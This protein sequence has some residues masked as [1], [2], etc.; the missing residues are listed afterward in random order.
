MTTPEM[1]VMF[2]QY[3][4]QM[5]MQNVRAILPEQIDLVLN[6]SQMDV[7]NQII[8]ENIGITNDRIISDNSKIGQVNALRS[9]YH[10]CH[11]DM[12][13]SSSQLEETRAF[14]FSAADRNT[15]RMT[16]DFKKISDNPLIPDYMFLVDF[17][18]NYKKVRNQQGYN[19][20]TGIRIKGTYSVLTPESC[21]NGG[22]TY[23]QAN[24]NINIQIKLEAY[25]PITDNFA[26][27]DF[28]PDT[29]VSNNP[30]LKCTTEGFTE[31]YLG[32]EGNKDDGSNY[33][34]RHYTLTKTF[35]DG[36]DNYNKGIIYNPLVIHSNNKISDYVAPIFEE[37]GLETNYFPVRI[38]DDAYLADTLNDFILKNRLRSPIIVT[39]NNNKKENIFD[40]YIDKF[41]KIGSGTT[42]KY[43][44][45]GD[46]LPY[47]LR[48]SY[49]GKPINIYYGEDLGKPNQDCSL[50]E[51]MHVDIVK[52]AVDLWRAAVTGSVL[53][54]QQQEQNA[55][56]ENMRNNYRNEGNAQ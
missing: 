33:G 43:V 17:S 36:D 5:G 50:P 19:G 53:A 15:G 34:G 31:Y 29:S 2:R 30:R 37:D 49:I 16:T 44:L 18:L 13:P 9:L 51:Y 1:H 12:S 4:Q 52:H 54:A 28:I 8:K 11:I 39:Y 21:I 42:A 38:I 14:S 32:V 7:I 3:A 46:L 56:Q 35:N 24:I 6:T 27:L 40:L 22:N 23:E 10:V 47:K 41:K 45:D 26:N 20:Q 55:R 25:E 48:M